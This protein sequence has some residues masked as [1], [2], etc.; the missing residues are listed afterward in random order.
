MKNFKWDTHDIVTDDG[1]MIQAVAP[2]VISASRSTDIPAF[3]ADWFIRRY[4][5]RYCVWKNPFNQRSQYISFAKSRVVVFWTKNPAPII[6]RLSEMIDLNYYFQFTLND[7]Q[8]TGLEPGL[9][10]LEERAATFIKLAN[11]IG[12]GRV[13]WRFDPLI[14]TD[15]INVDD[16][17]ARVERVGNLIHEF[18]SKLVFSFVDIAEYRKVAIN[19]NRAGIS[20]REF[21]VSETERFCAGLVELNRKWG[22]TLATCGEQIDLGRFG[23]VHNRCIDGELMVQEF[24]NDKKLMSFLNL[25]ERGTISLPLGLGF[26]W[27]RFKDKGQRNACGCIVSKDIGAYNTCAHGCIYCYANTSPASAVRNAALAGKGESI[28]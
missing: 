15:S 1:A 16:L 21:Q 19:L 12:K 22:L 25:S 2:I 9:P 5:K 26:D 6:P 27:S 8:N 24:R 4:K 3:Y 10:S 13:I 28:S 11:L 20:W 14:L 18:T 23:I 7:Y 17:L